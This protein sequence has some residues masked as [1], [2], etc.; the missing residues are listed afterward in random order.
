MITINGVDYEDEE[1][2]ARVLEEIDKRNEEFWEEEEARTDIVRPLSVEEVLKTM[3]VSTDVASSLPDEA[4]SLMYPY[5]DDWKTDTEYHKNDIC[6]YETYTYRCLQDHKSQ[7]SWTPDAA[8][9]LWAKILPGQGGDVGEWEQPGS[10]NPYMKGDKVRHNDKVW[11]SD[12]DNNVWEPGVYGW[13]E[14]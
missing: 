10:T 5:F 4:L 1:E 6:S 14:A 9:S 11:V 3:L 8:A 2:A 13:S 7:D 12:I